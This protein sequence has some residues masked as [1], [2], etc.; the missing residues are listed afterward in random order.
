MLQYD[1]G[2]FVSLDKI[3]H[4]YGINAE[5]E[6]SGKDIYELYMKSRFDDIV[7]HGVDD[8]NRVYRLV[9]ETELAD[10]FFNVSVL[11]RN[12]DGY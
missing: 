8:I 11:G 9:H 2:Y 7:A 1:N 3:C 5:C 4:Q 12:N 10:R 6:Y